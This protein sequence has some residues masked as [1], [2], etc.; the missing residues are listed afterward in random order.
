M[1]ASRGI[2]A[3]IRYHDGRGSHEKQKR[4]KKAWCILGW[5]EDSVRAGAVALGPQRSLTVFEDWV[6][7]LFEEGTLKSVVR[8][9][10]FM[11]S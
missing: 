2:S 3:E 4:Q 6:L 10:G 11:F 1:S 8:F 9:N 5:L 7:G